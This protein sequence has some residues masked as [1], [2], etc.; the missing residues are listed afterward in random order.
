MSSKTDDSLEKQITLK[1][2]RS[3][4]TK[5][6]IVMAYLE[7]LPFAIDYKAEFS[8]FLVNKYIAEA[9]KHREIDD[10]D[11]RSVANWSIHYLA[12]LIRAIEKTAG[13]KNSLVDARGFAGVSAKAADLEPENQIDGHLQQPERNGNG[14]RKP[15][16][17]QAM[18]KRI[19]GI[20][21]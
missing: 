14:H 21:E 9:L 15:P 18:A 20:D 16:P 5:L 2:R 3:S 7:D 10:E 8:L 11:L 12:S 6:S 4:N 1:T 13:F 19:I 17:G